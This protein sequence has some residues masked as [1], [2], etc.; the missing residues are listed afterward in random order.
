M[1]FLEYLGGASA[2]RKLSKSIGYMTQGIVNYLLQ[3]GVQL[4]LPHTA[5]V[6]RD[7]YC[8]CVFISSK[9][10]KKQYYYGGVMQTCNKY[11][12]D[13]LIDVFQ[14]QDRSF[15][16]RNSVQALIDTLP[17]HFK[18]WMEELGTDNPSFIGKPLADWIP[19]A[20]KK[21]IDNITSR[22]VE[23]FPDLPEEFPSTITAL[24][25]RCVRKIGP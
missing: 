24:A 23:D 16:F 7:A 14:H 9:P 25:E 12:F 13:W 4:Q 6:F 8:Y 10:R 22:L 21:L 17:S 3:N 11:L 19:V 5:E 2:S 15:D 18:T 1:G 20:T